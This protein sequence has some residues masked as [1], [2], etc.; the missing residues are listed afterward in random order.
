[1]EY[2]GVDVGF[3][4][5]KAFNGER[6]II[7]KSIVGDATEIQFQSGF[8][9][10]SAL[11]NLHITVD[12]REYFIGDM[13]EKQSNV[14]EF[15][16]DQNTMLENSARIMALTAISCYCTRPRQ[17]FSV[18]TGLP[19]RY[20]KQLRPRFVSLIE[21]EHHLI[22]HNRAGEDQEMTLAI[23]N[24]RVL[25]QPFGSVFNLMMN[26]HGR[27]VDRDMAREKFGVIDIGFRTTD[28]TVTDKL[29]Y[30]ERGSRTTDTGI[31]KAFSLI[32]KK[33]L[34]QSGVNVELYRLFEPVRN[35]KIRIRGKDYSLAE[36][37]DQVLKQLATSIVSDMERLW[38]DDW[39]LEFI[40]LSG[41]GSVDMAPILEKMIEGQ[42]RMVSTLND[43]RLVNVVGYLKYA[44][45]IDLMGK[46][47]SE[48][49]DQEEEGREEEGQEE[50]GREEETPEA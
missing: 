21:G 17:E 45:Y 41:G 2:L 18:V 30:I 25:P 28:Y 44:K 26:D 15:T 9:E 32:S 35:G 27:I 46:R 4:Y 31:S 29:R 13:A 14:R 3:G 24:V 23:K 38:V 6:S 47:R 43:A 36:L 20:Y 12:G 49:E 22:L 39:D 48:S 7:F 34:E 33:I 16:L 40:L 37:R 1:M 10:G 11:E 42:C 50:E 19:I 8:S 5:T